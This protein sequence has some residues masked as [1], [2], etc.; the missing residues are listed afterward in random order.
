M[1]AA[2]VERVE[3]VAI[4]E[5][6]SARPLVASLDDTH[7][8]LLNFETVVRWVVERYGDLLLRRVRRLLPGWWTIAPRHPLQ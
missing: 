6:A 7:Y 4:R 2:A 8:Y 3:S 1:H 5:P